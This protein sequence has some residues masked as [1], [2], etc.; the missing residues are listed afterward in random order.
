MAWWFSQH[1]RG[2]CIW[3]NGSVTTRIASQW[4]TKIPT[5][6]LAK[7]A[8]IVILMSQVILTHPYKQKTKWPCDPF[9]HTKP[10]WQAH[11]HERNS[12]QK[13]NM[14]RTRRTSKEAHQICVGVM[15]NATYRKHKY[16]GNQEKIWELFPLIIFPQSQAPCPKA[17][18][19]LMLTRYTGY[20]MTCLPVCALAMIINVGNRRSSA[21]RWLSVCCCYATKL[22]VTHQ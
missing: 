13:N 9:W 14:G 15:R 21:P 4:Y 12:R 17:V 16:W 2:A 18:I 1:A 6:V 11:D 20:R 19:S 10:P 5:S 3:M 22:V 8:S 7:P